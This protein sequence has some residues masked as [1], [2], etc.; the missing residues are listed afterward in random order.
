ME[1]DKYRASEKML[2]LIERLEKSK[3]RTVSNVV[4]ARR[5]RTKGMTA[6]E[7]KPRASASCSVTLVL[8]VLNSFRDR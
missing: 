8:G 2:L 6:F 1:T 4:Y 3:V 5:C 7:S